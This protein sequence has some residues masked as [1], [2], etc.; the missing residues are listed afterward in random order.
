VRGYGEENKT[1]MAMFHKGLFETLTLICM[2]ERNLF[3]AS[4]RI[5]TC[6]SIYFIKKSEVQF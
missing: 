4:C 5:S 2:N 3:K 1:S 6:T